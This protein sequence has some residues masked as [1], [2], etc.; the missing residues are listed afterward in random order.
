MS[1]IRFAG[2]A[3]VIDVEGTAAPIWFVT[4]V[5][6]PFARQGMRAFLEAHWDDPEVAAARAQVARDA[7]LTASPGWA[8]PGGVAAARPESLAA[9]VGHLE[10]LMAADAKQTGL[11]TLQG[12]VWRAGY[13]S[14]ELKARVFDDVA[15]ALGRWA[16]RGLDVRVYSSG[17]V[18][19]QKLFFGGT[20]A[21]DLRGYLKGYYDTAVGGKR[22][23][24]SYRAIA[25][26]IGVEP[27]A[28]LFLS[29]VPAE[30][31]AA[32]AAG[33]ATGLLMRPGNAPLSGAPG[34]RMIET[35]DDIEL[36]S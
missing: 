24:A 18:L 29:D 27:D 5:L 4:E 1:V 32:A 35:F 9:L 28:A 15:A 30:L 19:A 22:E 36:E 20:T 3:I 8:G 34:H 17:S 10:G 26:D 6:F 25:A 11:K 13:E 23:A 21:G 12:L 7:G 33:M 2:S 31:D 14:G 16:A